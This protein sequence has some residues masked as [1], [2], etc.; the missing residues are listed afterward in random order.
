MRSSRS[1][2]SV[3]AVQGFN[4]A[5]AVEV[6]ALKYATTKSNM[7]VVSYGT[8]RD[9]NYLPKISSFLPPQ[10]MSDSKVCVLVKNNSLLLG[11]RQNLLI[12]PQ[13]E[14]KRSFSLFSLEL[15]PSLQVIY[16]YLHQLSC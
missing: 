8:T 15:V 16:I 14:E 9:N 10:K 4:K 12:P 13:K 11:Y 1:V 6:E 5:K 7:Q 3:S 2:S